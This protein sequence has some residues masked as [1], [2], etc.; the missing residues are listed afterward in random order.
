VESTTESIGNYSLLVYRSEFLPQNNIVANMTLIASGVTAQSY[1]W[2]D[3]T[4]TGY[5]YDQ[6]RELYYAVVPRHETTGT[7]GEVSGPVTVITTPDKWTRYVK[8]EQAIGFRLTGESLVVLKKKT[9]GTFCEFYDQ[10]MGKHE[11]N[12]CATCYDTGFTGGYYD[13]IIVSG[14]V[15]AAPKKQLQMDWGEWQPMDAMV[16]FEA[17]PVIQPKDVLVDRLNRR[18]TVINVRPTM[19]GLSLIIQNVHIRLLPKED[20]MYKFTVVDLRDYD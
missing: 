15:N 9:F 16:T 14:I 3:V 4:V 6:H 10:T 11:T 8:L 18:W 12:N 7:E 20:I 5:E 17:Y 13:A 19:K 2:T 1:D